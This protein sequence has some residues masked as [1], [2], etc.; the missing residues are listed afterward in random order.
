MAIVFHIIRFLPR[1]LLSRIVGA[2]SELALPTSVH[3]IVIRG[4]VLLYRVNID[5]IEKP[6][7][8]Y[9]TFGEFFCR[10]LKPNAR[11]IGE[12]FVSPVDGVFRGVIP[13]Q[14][15]STVSVKESLFTLPV[16]LGSNDWAEPYRGGIC[17]EFY[18]SPRHYH[19]VHMPCGGRIVASRYIHGDLWPVEDVTRTRV[20]YLFDRNRRIAIK[21]ETEE[22]GECMLIMVGAFNV[23]RILTEFDD[24]SSPKTM[25]QET[26][27]Y[28]NPADLRK[29]EKV[30]AFL[31]GSTV[32]FLFP[33]TQDCDARF[34]GKEVL[35]GESI[36]SK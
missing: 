18:L 9:S 6:I 32:L 36:F 13:L 24:W 15:S 29:G 5:E 8:R 11:L 16:L 19:R 22:H 23:G 2:L 35:V 14:E 33:R 27:E 20:P 34:F 21:I 7:S 12:G 26:R 28:S 3:R 4:F 31:L 17:Y 25:P 1:V 30:G 10:N